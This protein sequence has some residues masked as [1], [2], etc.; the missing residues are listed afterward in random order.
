MLVTENCFVEAVSRLQNYIHKG[1]PHSFM[2]LMD[3]VSL[4]LYLSFDFTCAL[5]AMLH[6]SGIDKIGP[7]SVLLVLITYWDLS[8]ELTS[9]HFN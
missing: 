4:G 1:Q 3:A 5:K 8:Y 7:H 9:R 2:P 6:A